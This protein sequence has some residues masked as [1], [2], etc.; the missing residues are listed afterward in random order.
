M[1]IKKSNT[2]SEGVE[3]QNSETVRTYYENGKLK[4]VGTFVEGDILDS[5]EIYSEDGELELFGQL[6]DGELL[7]QLFSNGLDEFIN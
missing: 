2:L 3:N 5:F 1:T 7:E 4:S 6:I